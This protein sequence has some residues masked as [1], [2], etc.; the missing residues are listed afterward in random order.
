MHT[1]P[2]KAAKQPARKHPA[3]SAEPV[4]SARSLTE[5]LSPAAA[6][7]YQLLAHDFGVDDP[8]GKLLLR[9]AL[10]AWDRANEARAAIAR[11][12]LTVTCGN[13]RPIAHPM[14]QV[15]RDMGSAFRAAMRALNFDASGEPNPT[16]RPPFIVT[17]RL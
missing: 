17:P 8:A 10:E 12:G 16:G 14:L 11:D 5:G 15:E 7:W 3:T 1:K 4:T 6:T 2:R 13:G 9:H